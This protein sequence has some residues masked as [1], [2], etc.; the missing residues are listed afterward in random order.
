MTRSDGV[1]PEVVELLVA[2]AV[3]D[4]SAGPGHQGHLDALAAQVSPGLGLETRSAVA[5]S[6]KAGV[7]SSGA[8]PGVDDQ[9]AASE[10]PGNGEPAERPNW[11]TTV[12][13]RS[14]R[15]TGSVTTRPAGASGERITSGTAISS[16]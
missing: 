13:G 12:A 7:I 1:A 16:R 8:C 3:A 11:S 2:Q 6:E 4:V 9:E 15:L 10:R 14:R 5:C